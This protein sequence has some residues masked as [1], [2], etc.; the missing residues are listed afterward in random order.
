MAAPGR[1]RRRRRSRRRFATST[2]RRATPTTPPHACGTT[3]SSNRAT[4]ALCS[5]WH[6]ASLGASRSILSPTEYSG[7]DRGAGRVSTHVLEGPRGQPRRDRRARDPHTAGTRRRCTPPPRRRRVPA[8][9]GSRAR[10]SRRGWP[11]GPSRTWV[12]TRPAPRS[13]PEYS[14]GDRIERDAPNDAECQPEHSAGVARFDDAV[15]PQA[16]GGVVGVA[17]R[18]VLVANRRLERLLLLGRPGAAIRLDLVASHGRQHTRG[19]LTA[20]HRDAGTWPRPQ[21]TRRVRPATHGVVAGSERPADDHGEFGHPGAGHGS[22]HFCAVLGDATCLVVAPHHEPGD[23][24]QEKQ[25]DLALVA[26][27]DEVRALHRRL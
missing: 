16:C 1:P 20:H 2:R 21:K 3:A 6:S 13:H 22:H 26:Q 7:C 24:L 11:R 25:W 27:F 9:C 12:E 8:V 4:P 23:V 14:V 5:G 19:L 10:R 15:V 18:L 17:L